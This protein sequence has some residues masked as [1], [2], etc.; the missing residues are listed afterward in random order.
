MR[1]VT[2]RSRS[3]ASLA[4]DD[5]GI[6]IATIG[7]GRP[8]SSSEAS[9]ASEEGS[10]SLPSSEIEASDSSSSLDDS[11][12]FDFDFGL[13][14]GTTFFVE[15]ALAVAGRFAGLL[16]GFAGRGRFT[17][18]EPLEAAPWAFVGFDG[19]AGLG[20]AADGATGLGFEW[21]LS[22]GIPLED[23]TSA[24]AAT[25]KGTSSESSSPLEPGSIAFHPAPS[26]H[27]PS[28]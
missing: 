16:C 23:D 19:F 26:S 2:S 28:T 5:T 22:T 11:E 12:S 20:T 15:L 7:W 10:L 17:G 25:D 13:E 21:P 8:P 24:A 1:F 6:P 3:S 9:S 18:L 4:R 27:S 14:A